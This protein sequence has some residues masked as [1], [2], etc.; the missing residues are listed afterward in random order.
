MLPNVL[1]RNHALW[2]LTGWVAGWPLLT[3]PH[4]AETLGMP[5]DLET[6]GV[7]CAVAAGASVIPDL[8]HPDARPARH[9]GILSRLLAKGISQAAGGHRMATHSV[10]FAAMLAAV[11]YAVGWLPTSAGAW[12]AALAAGFCCSVGC[13][14]IGPSFGIR[15]PGLASMAIAI[16]SGWWV[17]HHFSEIRWVLPVI[18]AY[19]VLAHIACDFVTKGGVPVL[20]P[21]SKRRMALQLFTVGGAGE[22]VAAALGMVLLGMAAWR[23]VLVAS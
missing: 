7:T 13:A 9:F 6:F 12:C 3:Q 11:T 5:T 20:W 8:D 2:G 22:H 16:G 4:V 21:F 18:A 15:I 19:G 23:V 17:W 10:M 1:G 14:L